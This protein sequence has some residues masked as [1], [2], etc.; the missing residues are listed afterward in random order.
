MMKSNIKTKTT[1]IYLLRHGKV[2][3]APALYGHTNVEVAADVN[4]KILKHLNKFQQKSS[5]K[6]THVI[7]SPLQRCN[8][9]AKQFALHNGLALDVVNN[10]Q[11]MNFGQLDGRSF[12]DIQ[13]DS[14]G[15]Q[16]WQQLENFW[17]DPS[18]FP[19]PQAEILSQFYERVYK[20]WQALINEHIGK[21]ILLVCHGGVIR[22]I[23]AYVL[24]LDYRNKSLFSQLT[25]KNSSI[26]L[27]NYITELNTNHQHS[28]IVTVSTPLKVL[29]KHPKEF[30]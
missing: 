29:S 27:V 7:T 28:Q 24:T 9:V 23:L 10:F 4:A 19:L 11:E 8:K 22:M 21:N 13:D 6:I 5:N 2:N 3:G 26:T 18:K 25:I 1:R 15:K 30:E 17:H 12:D 20:A 16:M 14:N